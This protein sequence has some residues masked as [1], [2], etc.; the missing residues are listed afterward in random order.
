MKFERFY[1]ESTMQPFEVEEDTWVMEPSPERF[2]IKLVGLDHSV[3]SKD[4]MI[5]VKAWCD[6]RDVYNISNLIYFDT[7]AQRFEF[8]MAWL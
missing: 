4:A 3:D 7:E 1:L 6:A 8:E 2:G 5:K